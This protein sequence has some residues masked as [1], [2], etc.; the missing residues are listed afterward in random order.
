MATKETLFI[1]QTVLTVCLF[2]GYVLSQDV[3][4]TQAQS[5]SRVPFENYRHR[6]KPSVKRILFMVLLFAF[7]LFVL[8]AGRLLVHDHPEHSNVIVVLAGD[9]QDQRYRR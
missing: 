8:F 3:A 7:F 4:E 2:R 5:M 1:T 9:S 6:R